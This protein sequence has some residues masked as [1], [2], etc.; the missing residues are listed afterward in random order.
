MKININIPNKECLKNKEIDSLIDS[1]SILDRED[2]IN[3]LEGAEITL[4]R[5]LKFKIKRK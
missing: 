5:N 2:F 3:I 4:G 1:L